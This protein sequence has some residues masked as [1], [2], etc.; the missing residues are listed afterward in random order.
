MIAHEAIG[1]NAPVVPRTDGTEQIEKASMIVVIK[2]DAG[3]GVAA[4]RHMIEG[5][6]ILQT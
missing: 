2:K 1:R 3:A 4:G 6:G 5:A